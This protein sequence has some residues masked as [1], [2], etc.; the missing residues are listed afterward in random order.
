MPI[1]ACQVKHAAG[2]ST[3]YSCPSV[4]YQFL[5]QLAVTMDLS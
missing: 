3:G 4:T 1:Y 5:R 2:V